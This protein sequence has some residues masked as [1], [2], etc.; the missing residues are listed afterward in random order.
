MMR[1]NAEKTAAARGTSMLRSLRSPRRGGA[2]SRNRKRKALGDAHFQG[3][4]LLF[5]WSAGNNFYFVYR[6]GGV[7]LERGCC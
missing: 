6:F 5:S 3:L 4:L 7:E 1:D 2:A